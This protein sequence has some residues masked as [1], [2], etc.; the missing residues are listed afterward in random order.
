VFLF[1]VI[2]V[3]AFSGSLCPWQSCS[4][5]CLFIMQRHPGQ[6]SYPTHL[7]LGASNSTVSAGVCFRAEC[8]WFCAATCTGCSS[9][10][11][12]CILCAA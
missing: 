8:G 4:S 12:F 6:C 2:A 1:A 5:W 11:T 7:D 9:R 10:V 3:H